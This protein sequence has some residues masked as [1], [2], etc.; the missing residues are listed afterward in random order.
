MLH[1]I[2]QGSHE[3]QSVNQKAHFRFARCLFELKR[4]GEA[5]KEIDEYREVIGGRPTVAEKDLRSKIL[6]AIMERDEGCGMPPTVHPPTV[7]GRLLRYEV[8][9]FN[10]TPTIILFDD[11]PGT[12]CSKNPPEI[13]SRLYAVELVTKYHNSILQQNEWLCWNCPAPA[14]SLIHSP[15][16]YFHL[17]EPKIVDYAQPICEDGGSC[18]ISARKMMAETMRLTATFS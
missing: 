6:H 4:F 5:I 17:P 10:S 1:S 9:V 14:I 2:P 16:L 8:K 12:L 3:A 11:I 7:P 18:D 15:A 13:P